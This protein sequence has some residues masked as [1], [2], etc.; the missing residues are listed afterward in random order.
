MEAQGE[1]NG[2]TGRTAAS[3]IEAAAKMTLHSWRAIAK[4]TTLVLAS[5]PGSTKSARAR[6]TRMRQPPLNFLVARACA[7]EGKT[8]NEHLIP[9]HGVRTFHPPKQ[10]FIVA[11]HGL[12]RTPALSTCMS[13]VKDRPA[14]MAAARACAP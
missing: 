13:G 10:N 5:A 12:S 14:R 11:A 7:A 1:L 8:C 4:A 6:A 3:S 2:H 9:G